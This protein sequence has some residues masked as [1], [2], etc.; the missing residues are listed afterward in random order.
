MEE[1]SAILDDIEQND[2]KGVYIHDGVS[3]TKEGSNYQY[4]LMFDT[5]YQSSY[6]PEEF[7]NQ[8]KKATQYC[9]NYSEAEIA[10]SLSQYSNDQFGIAQHSHPD[11]SS[12]EESFSKLSS[13]DLQFEDRHDSFVKLNL[14]S[15]SHSSSA[16][17]ALKSSFSTLV[18]LIDGDEDA[19]KNGK[20]YYKMELLRQPKR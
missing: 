18:K 4:G 3:E 16:Y 1:I 10:E 15:S 7:F 13:K 5:K 20:A 11:S 12:D 6:I 9:V 2:S 8:P 19:V 17:F 14:K